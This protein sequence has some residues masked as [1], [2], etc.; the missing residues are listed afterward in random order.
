MN[1]LS[2]Y[3]TNL[4][5][6]EERINKLEKELGAEGKVDKCDKYISSRIKQIESLKSNGVVLNSEDKC[7]GCDGYK[8]NCDEYIVH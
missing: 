4:L 5:R 8:K 3:H 1:G 2:I 6:I 7:S